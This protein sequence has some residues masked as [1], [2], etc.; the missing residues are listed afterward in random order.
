MSRIQ[1]IACK[2]VQN[3]KIDDDNRDRLKK[4]IAEAAQDNSP[5]YNK[6]IA[7]VT[8]VLAYATKP[9]DSDVMSNAWGY[10]TCSHKANF[11]CFLQGAL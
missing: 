5:G 8:E 1:E 10:I 3:V 11:L 7:L 6:A 2:L 9:V 4:E